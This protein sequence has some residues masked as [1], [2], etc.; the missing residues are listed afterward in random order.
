MITADL[1]RDRVQNHVPS[2]L[3][4]STLTT[5]S[6]APSLSKHPL[7]RDLLLPQSVTEVRGVGLDHSETQ[8]LLSFQPCCNEYLLLFMA[9]QHSWTPSLTSVWEHPISSIHASLRLRL[10]NRFLRS[11]AAGV[12]ARD[13]D[14]V[15]QKHPWWSS[16]GGREPD[17]EST[18]TSLAA[19]TLSLR[20]QW[21][22][23]LW[24]EDRS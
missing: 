12:Q 9:A 21:P 10:D 3:D 11:S 17:M 16:T 13:P 14:F 1:L 23:V 20:Q 19:E 7:S 24:S 15:S 8:H 2:E 6:F 5:T 18:L 4:G 22:L